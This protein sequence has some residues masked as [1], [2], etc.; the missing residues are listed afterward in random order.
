MQKLKH[1]NIHRTNMQEV[2]PYY[3]IHCHREYYNHDE[4]VG[5][6]QTVGV[7]LISIMIL[8]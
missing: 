4:P 2:Q 5:S 3:G 8:I 6:Q 1:N 7:I